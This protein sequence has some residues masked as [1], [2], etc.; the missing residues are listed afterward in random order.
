MKSVYSIIYIKP[1]SL[2]SEKIAVALMLVSESKVWFEFEPTKVSLAEKF[3][4]NKSS[5]NSISNTLKEIKTFLE[6]NN[7]NA[8]L[9]FN[10]LF[11]EKQLIKEDYLNYLHHY[12]NNIIHFSKPFALSLSADDKIFNNLLVKFLDYKLPKSGDHKK[13]NFHHQFKTVLKEANIEDKVDFDL[14]LTPKEVKGIYADTTV[15]VIG[16]NGILTA[17]NNIDFQIGEETLI[18][19]LNQWDVLINSLNEFSKNK[20]WGQGNYYLFFNKPEP[21]SSQEKILNTISKTKNTAFHLT[22]FDEIDS[23]IHKIQEN[24]Y[25]PLSEFL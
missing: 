9:Y 7:K 6:E 24:D 1:N 2:T 16:K 3:F 18:N 20:K 12:S 22:D 4:A 25:Q 8:N 11:T 10:E 17:A 5:I 14:I 13:M 21:K 19:H 15:K 23:F